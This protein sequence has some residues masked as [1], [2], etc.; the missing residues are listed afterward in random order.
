MIIFVG[1]ENIKEPLDRV[2]VSLV[3]KMSEKHLRAGD[4]PL[5]SSLVPSFTN[6]SI[7]FVCEPYLNPSS[8][9]MISLCIPLS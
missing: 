5:L 3:K 8:S 7:L 1:Q 4:L 9:V 2:A 6:F